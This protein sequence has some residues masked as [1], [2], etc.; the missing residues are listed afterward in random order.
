MASVSRALASAMLLAATC[1]PGPAK[2][3]MPMRRASPDNVVDRRW[4][5]DSPKRRGDTAE[6]AAGLFTVLPPPSG[7]DGDPSSE[8]SMVPLR[9]PTASGHAEESRDTVYPLRLHHVFPMGVEVG[10][11]V[12]TVLN[13]KLES[14]ENIS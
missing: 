14:R 9:T 4:I 13:S 7:V 6:E 12:C 10:L 8:K 11:Y 2:A 5:D 3:F 1:F